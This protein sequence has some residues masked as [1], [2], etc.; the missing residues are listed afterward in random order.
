MAYLCKPA[1]LSC[2]SYLAISNV[3]LVGLLELDYIF[4]LDIKSFCTCAFNH[5]RVLL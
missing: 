2:F 3:F 1:P 5:D 4:V